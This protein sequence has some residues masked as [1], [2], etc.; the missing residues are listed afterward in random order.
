LKSRYTVLTCAF[1]QHCHVLN[2][3]DQ[4]MMQVVEI[5]PS[6]ADLIDNPKAAGEPVIRALQ[7]H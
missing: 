6:D 4:G 1:V 3:E 2:H 5:R 7:R